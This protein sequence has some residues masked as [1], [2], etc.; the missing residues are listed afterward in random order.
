MKN[1]HR[2]VEKWKLKIYGSLIGLHF[3][4]KDEH[5]VM[6]LHWWKKDMSVTGNVVLVRSE[7]V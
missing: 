2:L 1:K 6:L 7:T 5:D 4:L 3:L